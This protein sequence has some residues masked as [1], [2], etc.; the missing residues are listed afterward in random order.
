[1][2]SDEQ[3]CVRVQS[4]LKEVAAHLEGMPEREQQ[5]LLRQLE[6]HI[7]EALQA[8]T[9][10][11]DA[12][13]SD[14]EA[15]LLEMDPPESYGTVRDGRLG[16]LRRGE[17]ALLISLGSLVVAGLLVLLSGGRMAVWIPVFLFLGS[18]VAAF[19][20]GILSWRES[21]GKAAV[22]TSGALSI[23]AVLCCA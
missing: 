23:L 14:V 15:V 13:A 9:G 12:Q 17:W 19:V 6:S 8:R 20:I 4:Y 21:C 22:F 7:H 3:V 18:Q 5:D 2:N 10:G 16:R 11:K 1:M